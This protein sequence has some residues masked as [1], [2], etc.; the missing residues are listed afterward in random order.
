MEKEDKLK[1]PANV[2]S[3]VCGI[4]SVLGF[5]FYYIGVPLGT[6]AIIFGTKGIKKTGSKLA[7]AGLIL[8]II[9]TSLTF[10]AYV[11]MASAIIVTNM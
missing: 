6:L 3:F 4:I 8:G 9:G 11:L 2:A 10:L 7:K 1:S 5:L